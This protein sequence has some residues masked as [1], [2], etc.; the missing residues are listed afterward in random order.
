MTA[1][2]TILQAGQVQDTDLS[3]SVFR[4]LG[5]GEGREARPLAVLRVM[6]PDGA[7]HEL[8]LTIGQ[9]VDVEGIGRIT[10]LAMEPSTREQRGWV[11][12]AHETPPAR[13]DAD[14]SDR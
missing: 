9:H 14:A 8:E 4:T 10:L 11:R 12:I 6:D 13:S 5:A 7:V 1:Q 3:L 2:H